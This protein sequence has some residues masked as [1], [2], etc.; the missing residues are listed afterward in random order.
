MAASN[1]DHNTQDLRDRIA[2]GNF[3][4]WTVAIQ[5]MTPEESLKFEYDVN[6]LTKV[7][8]EDEFPLLEV[9]KIV[10]NKNPENWFA[11]IEQ[12]AF[13]PGNM[14]PGAEPS[15]DP[16][17][18]SRLFSYGDTAR[19]RLGPN[20]MQIPINCPLS[21]QNFQRAGWMRVDG[22]AG[23]LPP[24]APNYPSSFAAPVS[25][26]A[27]RPYN[28]SAIMDPASDSKT[29]LFS[30]QLSR[31]DFEQP[32]VL[33]NKEFDDVERQSLIDNV[34]GA[35]NSVT[36]PEVKQRSLDMFVCVDTTLGSKIGAGIGLT[37]SSSP[38]CG[39]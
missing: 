35:L 27:G 6:D 13:T 10:L 34:I 18:Q 2:A 25:F 12:L 5:T 38:N 39:A 37:P 11:E 16:V 30:Y 3:P 17:L 36:I 20:H 9:G 28:L 14:I 8:P 26:N 1:P 15:N 4:T 24:S 23:T 32:N 19:H 31:A 7:W 33:F 21:V 22:G 29:V